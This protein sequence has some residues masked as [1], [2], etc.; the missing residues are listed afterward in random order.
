MIEKASSN[1]RNLFR[2]LGLLLIDFIIKLKKVNRVPR[3]LLVIRLDSIGDY[4]LFRNFLKVINEDKRYKNYKLTL[5]GNIV[6]KDIAETF[7]RGIVDDFI[8]VDRLLFLNNFKYKFRILNQIYKKGFEI[9]IDTI[10]SREILFGDIIVNTSGAKEKIGSRITG[11]SS[12]LRKKL[13]SDRFYTK[14]VP[15]SES[16]LFEFE[17]NK[18]FFS[19]LLEMK[20][21]ITKPELDTSNIV[22]PEAV[23]KDYIVF[24]PGASRPDKMWG[25]SNFKEVLF[26]IMNNYSYDILLSGSLKESYLYNRIVPDNFTSRCHN[27]FGNSLP[28]L[29]KIISE[30]KLLISNDT[31]AVHFAAA[32]NTPF[33]CIANGLYYGRFYPYPDEVFNKGY[34]LLPAEFVPD[35]EN[36]INKVQT[37]EVITLIKEIFKL[38]K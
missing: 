2:F 37:E 28:E 36:D 11:K 25:Y 12:K 6:W 9:V 24:F 7:D 1:I 19:S 26:F 17:R 20:I 27:Y 5:C 21:N 33:I 31:S 38:Y 32:T 29:A 34:Y 4:I 15:V 3:T 13:F 18:E 30:T 35:K 16:V 23:M 22:L 10:H 8:W 14:L